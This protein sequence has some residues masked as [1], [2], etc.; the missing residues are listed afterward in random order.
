MSSN[1][2]P[3]SELELNR[4]IMALGVVI[5][6]MLYGGV[7]TLALSYIPL[8]VE[9]SHTI[10]RRMR[11]FLL[12]YVIFMVALSTVNTVTLI[13]AFT[14]GR[15]ILNYGGQVADLFDL[16]TFPNG[17]AGALCVTFASW[18]ADGFMVRLSQVTKRLECRRPFNLFFSVR[19]GGVWCYVKEGHDFSDC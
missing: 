15:T 6:A 16:I 18:G 4:K 14:I 10:S 7:A 9:T 5:S 11:N 19:Y 3:D 8:L 2:G 12:L 1:D 13:I 17:L